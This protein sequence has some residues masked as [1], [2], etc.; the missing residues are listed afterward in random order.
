MEFP[1]QQENSSQSY[2]RT[3]G[4]CLNQGRNVQSGVKMKKDGQYKAPNLQIE[5]KYATC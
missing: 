2:R 1:Q 4:E 3:S 5:L